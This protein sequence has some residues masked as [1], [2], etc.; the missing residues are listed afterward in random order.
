MLSIITCTANRPKLYA[1]HIDAILRQMT[2]QCEYSV[3]YW[4][5]TDLLV[6]DADFFRQV[7]EDCYARTHNG[8]PRGAQ[9]DFFR[10]VD[11][12]CYWPLP[13]AYNA[14]LE[15]AT[16]DRL[17]IV[18]SDVI[19]APGLLDWALKHNEPGIAWC[20][21][22]VNDDGR[23]FVGPSRRVAIPYVLS[24][25]REKV[26]QMGGWSHEFCNGTCY[27]DN[28]FAARLLMTGVE[29]RWCDEFENV[30]QSHPRYGGSER[31]ARNAVNRAIWQRRL[32]GH[33]GRL[34]PVYWDDTK[35]LSIPE[36]AKCRQFPQE[37]LA[38]GLRAVGYPMMGD[39]S[40]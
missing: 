34:W 10:Q 9:A 38:S 32:N 18:G 39:Y 8:G 5:T 33:L 40:A 27:D 31:T 19:I 30:H 6:A 22:V 7:D 20:F 37:A 29:Y 25:A 21:R 4:G 14:A 2:D 23:E 36:S 26:L 15:M 3:V 1:R 17:L 12:D 24:V 13:K 11:E 28:D 16:G 35:P